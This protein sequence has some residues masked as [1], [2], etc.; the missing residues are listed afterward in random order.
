MNKRVIGVLIVSFVLAAT[1][2]AREKCM[3]V[4]CYKPWGS[5]QQG[6]KLPNGDVVYGRTRDCCDSLGRW[7]AEAESCNGGWRDWRNYWNWYI[8][9][10]AWW[11]RV[12]DYEFSSPFTEFSEFKSSQW[13]LDTVGVDVGVHTP[14]LPLGDMRLVPGFHAGI[15]RSDVSLDLQASDN[16]N[17]AF[18]GS[19]NLITAGAELVLEPS[20]KRPW[21]FRAG[22]D[23]HTLR[24]LD[25]YEPES[26]IPAELHYKAFDA[27][28]AVRYSLLG[29][30]LQPSLGVR[31]TDSTTRLETFQEY[32]ATTELD[33]DRTEVVAGTDVRFGESL[34]GRFE[35]ASN[36]DDHRTNAALT[37][38]FGRLGRIVRQ[39]PLPPEPPPPPPPPPVPFP[40]PEQDCHGGIP[41]CQKTYVQQYSY[42]G[43]GQI[44]E[45]DGTCLADG[46]N[47]S[48]WYVFTVQNPGSLTFTLN[49][50]N[51]YDF[52]LYDIT[53]T[54]C[55]GITGTTPMRCNY[56]GT[57]G[58]TGLVLPT[59]SGPLSVTA[60]GSPLMAGVDVA[61]GQTY[62]LLVDNFTRD[63]NGYTLN[64]GGTATIFDTTAPALASVSM[65]PNLGQLEVTTSEPVRCSSIAANG[66]DFSINAPEGVTVT[67]ASGVGCGT[68]TNKI[69]LTY[70]LDKP[71][72]CGIWKIVAKSGS[73]GNSLIDNCGN[74]LA[75]GAPIQLAMAPT[76]VPSFTLPAT[77]FCA[78]AA[79]IAD[80]SASQ[81]EERYF[82]SIVEA[83]A[84]WNVT[85]KECMHW[86]EGKAG[87]FDVTALA[88]S[89]G[90]ELK[91]DRYYRVKLAVQN[92]ATQWKETVQLIRIQC[93]PVADAGPDKSVCCCGPQ[94]L[95]IGAP[96]V[97][98]VQYSWSPTIGLDNPTLSNPTIDM[99]A[100][101]N[102]AVPFPSTY[103]VTATDALGCSA[104]DSVYVKTVCGCRPGANI[105]VS[106]PT[107][108]S[109]SKLT[110]NCACGDTT[111][112]YL[113]SNGATT[114]SI[115]VSN[116]GTYSVTCSN[117]C[118]ATVS[119]SVT[120]PAVSPLEGGFPPIQCPNVFTPNGDGVND[121]WTVTDLTKPAGYVPA[122][123][124]TEYELRVFNRW[125]NEIAILHGSTTTGF[126]NGTIPG[127]NGTAT[128]NVLYSWW[129]H[130]WGRTDTHAGDA[131][132]DGVYFYILKMR[133]CT[134]DWTT[135]CYG[136]THI[137]R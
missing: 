41:V 91:C 110:A 87:T 94:K 60:G 76:A 129:Q 12:A 34:S 43:S 122:Y 15:G 73:D 16:P 98:G 86:Y 124:A 130:L 17:V 46:E 18:R 50:Q 97:A 66:S 24:N 115:E 1:V 19:G 105:T 121:F 42:S 71:E 35:V 123:N 107:I 25:R 134:T 79:I 131:V 75:G 40:E 82:W 28:V 118:G 38:H 45:A 67:S 4:G 85:G 132:S 27:E 63:T 65:G 133:N 22:Y 2:E 89:E 104:K 100:F 112:T 135:V 59:A 136:F 83:D 116:G 109:K 29:D 20:A 23:Y 120:V 113:W 8:G 37:Y 81:H 108:C 9:A 99:S 78:G 44:H 47:G 54:G 84:N 64:F 137:F 80:G 32:R 58:P 62:A 7:Y 14:S 74:A 36:G 90:C 126:A 96:P 11:V 21:S 102:P 77:T 49:T 111:P 101:A 30:R 26:G 10:D 3:K 56:S 39:P 117:E 33:L 57:Y 128:E 13:S 125:G 127:W 69:H 92:C 55:G 106:E 88:R 52:A 93:P 48:V 51:D 103:E 53:T 70:T 68:F 61:A 119:K 5:C 95:Q 31:H 6:V 72:A 114:Q